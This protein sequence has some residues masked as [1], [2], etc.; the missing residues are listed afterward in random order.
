M[1]LP[2]AIGT[3]LFVGTGAAL[4]SGGPLGIFLAYSIM[5]ERS[6]TPNL[7][8]KWLTVLFRAGTIVFSMM[9]ALGEVNHTALDIPEAPA[10]DVVRR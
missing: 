9:N 2:T 7:R 4:S 3:G 10:D 8:C 6:T 1:D 5:G